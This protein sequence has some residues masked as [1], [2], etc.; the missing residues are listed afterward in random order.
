M[1][2]GERRGKWMLGRR[3]LS[4]WE[5]G[6]MSRAKAEKDELITQ[7]NYHTLSDNQLRG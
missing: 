4:D 7:K 1:K 3:D 5:G 6:R 2:D